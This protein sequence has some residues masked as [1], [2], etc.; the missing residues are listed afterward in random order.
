METRSHPNGSPLRP[1]G[2]GRGVED[3]ELLCGWVGAT[4]GAQPPGE[5]VVR[6]GWWGGVVGRGNGEEVMG[7][8]GRSPRVWEGEGRG[9]GS[10]PTSRSASGWGWHREPW[11]QCSAGEETEDETAGAEAQLSLS[12]TGDAQRG[13][14]Q[15]SSPSR[16]LRTRPPP[17]RSSRSSSSSSSVTSNHPSGSSSSAAERQQKKLRSLRYRK[18]PSFPISSPRAN[19]EHCWH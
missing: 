12:A 18:D 1:G 10:C 16:G 17:A 8:G 15:P 4:R 9:A 5:G 11:A 3:E 19:G 6:R 13:A 14:A 2:E 7:G